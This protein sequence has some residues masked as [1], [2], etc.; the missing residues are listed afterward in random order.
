MIKIVVV[1]CGLAYFL[2]AQARWRWGV[3]APRGVSHGLLR[4]M[5]GT[6]GA[7]EVAVQGRLV[8]SLDR[9]IAGLVEGDIFF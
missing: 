6:N 1:G 4:R 5:V 9:P 3:H 2:W 7:S 8:D